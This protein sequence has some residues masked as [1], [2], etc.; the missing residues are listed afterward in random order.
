MWSVLTIVVDNEYYSFMAGR[1]QQEI[2]Q[3]KPMRLL[4]EET[5]LNIA[6]T[7]DLLLQRFTAVLK[8]Y[9]ISSTQY[10]VLGSY[11]VL[12]QRA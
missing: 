6:R 9:A 3:H 5:A 8:P 10:N 1:L 2:Q 4:E 11:G 12:V 7:A